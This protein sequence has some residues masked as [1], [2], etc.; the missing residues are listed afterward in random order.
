MVWEEGSTVVWEEGEKLLLM[1]LGGSS[2]PRSCPKANQI[3]VESSRA[4]KLCFQLGYLSIGICPWN[5]LLSHPLP[6]IPVY[7]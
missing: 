1:F 7:F 5:Q 4:T 3:W 6:W 2:S